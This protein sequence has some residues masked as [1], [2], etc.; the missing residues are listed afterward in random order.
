MFP[1]FNAIYSPGKPPQSLLSL[2]VTDDDPNGTA[3]VEDTR[4]DETEEEQYQEMEGEVL[5]TRQCTQVNWG[6]DEAV[7]SGKL[8]ER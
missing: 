7:Y 5:E 8:G 4:D 2:A 3:D 1:I 6:R